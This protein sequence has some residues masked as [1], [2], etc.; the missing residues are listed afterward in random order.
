MRGTHL[1]RERLPVRLAI[2]HLEQ[3]SGSTII[4]RFAFG[5]FVM[6]RKKIGNTPKLKNNSEVR[7]S[8]CVVIAM[9]R[10]SS[11]F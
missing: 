9:V 6:S 4:E 5:Y 3:D 8:R 11:E 1:T 2:W 7:G 10:Q